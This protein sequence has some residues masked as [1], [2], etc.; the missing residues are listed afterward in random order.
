M[1]ELNCHIVVWLSVTS[2]SIQLVAQ[3]WLLQ[4]NIVCYHLHF[5]S[6]DDDNGDDDGDDGDNNDATAAAMYALEICPL[7]AY[8]TRMKDSK[9]SRNFFHFW[10]FLK[11]MCYAIM[12]LTVSSISWYSILITIKAL[13]VRNIL[14]YHTIVSY[15][16]KNKTIGNKGK[17]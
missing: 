2:L 4:R 7:Q 1:K 5:R 12:T 3:K 13:F 17:Y 10:E 8:T 16:T 9:K 14:T 15:N 11:A 6:D